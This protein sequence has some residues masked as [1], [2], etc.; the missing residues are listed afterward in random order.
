MVYV[1]LDIMRNW[2]KLVMTGGF[3]LKSPVFLPTNY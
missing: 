1:L 2:A 3:G